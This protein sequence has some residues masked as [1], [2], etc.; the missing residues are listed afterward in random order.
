M[1]LSK[2]FGYALRGIL[3]MATVQEEKKHIQLQEIAEQLDAPR[4]FLGKVMKRLSKQ[5]IIDSTKGHAGGYALNEHTLSTPIM[6]IVTLIEGEGLFNT[7]VIGF[8]KC[9]ELNPCP[10]HHQVVATKNQMIKIFNDTRIGDLLKEDKPAF[11]RS[12]VTA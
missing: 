5:G 9:N 3:Y 10:L 8:K 1:V 2:S 6:A 11:I 12:L 7:C 4:H